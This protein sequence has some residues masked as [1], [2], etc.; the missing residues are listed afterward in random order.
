MIHRFKAA[1]GAVALLLTSGALCTS[2]YAATG[3]AQHNLTSDVPNLADNLDSNLKN[4]WGASFGQSTPFWVSNQGS[5]NSTLYNAA[6]VP[7]PLVVSTPNSPTGQVFN[8]TAN[9]FNLSPGSKSLFI[10]STLSGNIAG[11]NGGSGTSTVTKFTST[12]GA[13]YTGLAIG[14]NGTGDFLYAANA[15]GNQIDVINSDFQKVTLPGS[16]LDPNLPAGLSVYNIQNLNGTL[17]VTYSERGQ[18]SGIVDAY[19][20]NGNLLRRFTDDKVLDQPWGLVIAPAGFGKFG[21]SLLVGNFGDGKINAFDLADGHFLG[22]VADV[23]GNALANPGLWSLNFR[24]PGSGFDPDTLFLTAGING[25]ANGLF[26]E[27]T[28]VPEP[29]AWLAVVL[30]M[31]AV[32]FVRRTAK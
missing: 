21:N 11:W 1:L 19:D 9:S 15:A 6:G 17:Y 25:E 27:I 2:S 26:A 16:F 4:P 8:S 10:F 30:G 31:L 22:T 28:A 5:N 13:V 3:Y 18:D 24:A 12:N 32:G 20:T 23:Q 7:Q 14:N 29:S